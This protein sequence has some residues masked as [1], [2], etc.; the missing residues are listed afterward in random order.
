[1]LVHDDY[2]GDEPFDLDQ[3]LLYMLGDD[4]NMKLSY[5]FWDE[6]VSVPD[7]DFA[8]DIDRQ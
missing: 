6:S 3:T 2:Q 7:S 8:G 1:M 5:M 4:T